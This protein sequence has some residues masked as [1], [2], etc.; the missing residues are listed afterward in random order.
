MSPPPRSLLMSQSE[1]CTG[2]TTVAARRHC[3]GHDSRSFWMAGTAPWSAA[4]PS[5]AVGIGSRLR[6]GHHRQERQRHRYVHPDH[7][8]PPLH[9]LCEAVDLARGA[10]LP[11][12]QQ[13]TGTA[14]RRDEWSLRM[15]EQCWHRLD[16]QESRHPVT[17]RI[18]PPVP[19]H[20]RRDLPRDHRRSPSH[21][22]KR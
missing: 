19:T 13:I 10:A 5:P 8:A 2:D 15:P 1:S 20:A 21:L 18:L 9:R 11:L 12:P 3:G 7:E 17:P 22:R 14:L 6:P 4:P 16:A